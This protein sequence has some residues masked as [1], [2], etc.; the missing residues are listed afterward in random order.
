M[1][2]KGVPRD[3][4]ASTQSLKDE[5]NDDS[6][7]TQ[8]LEISKTQKTGVVNGTDPTALILSSLQELGNKIE[9][10]LCCKRVRSAVS[11]FGRG[12]CCLLTS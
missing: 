11:Y 2:R 5:P 9:S 8:S 1:P 10:C 6:S 3:G 4:R 12:F 7:S